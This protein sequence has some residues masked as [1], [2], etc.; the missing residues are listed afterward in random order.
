MSK[1][2]RK[3]PSPGAT[4]QQQQHPQ[5]TDTESVTDKA[6]TATNPERK[7]S[8]SM[9]MRFGARRRTSSNSVTS[10]KDTNESIKGDDASDAGTVEGYVGRASA[11]HV[12][13][14]V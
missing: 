2:F 9:S 10:V 13:T 6:S 11:T 1:L 14:R 4:Q 7:M 12:E 8:K 5:A 3:S